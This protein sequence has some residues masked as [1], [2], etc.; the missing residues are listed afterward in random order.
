MKKWKLVVSWAVRILTAFG[1]LGA[2]LGKLTNNSEVIKM[3][4]DWGFPEGF[5]FIIGIFELLLAILL[6]I[7]KTLKIA[8]IG[9]ALIMVGAVITHLLNDPVIQLI[10]PFIF[11]VLLSI[12]YYINYPINKKEKSFK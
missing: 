10:R 6:V 11:L 2:S 9:L 7:P 4:E 12:I 8:I 1:F 5:H 3:F